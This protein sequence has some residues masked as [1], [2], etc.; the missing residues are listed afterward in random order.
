VERFDGEIEFPQFKV[1]QNQ[2]TSE[3]ALIRF[4]FWEDRKFKVPNL[5]GSC[6]TN[7]I[8]LRNSVNGELGVSLNQISTGKMFI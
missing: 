4:E 1:D 6:E 5:I 3:K 8:S 7:L 2:L